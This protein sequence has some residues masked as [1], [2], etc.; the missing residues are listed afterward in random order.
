[1]S[2][3]K[4]YKAHSE[5]PKKY[6]WDLSF[7][8]EGK[9]IEERMKELIS[10]VRGT[11][12]TKDSKYDSKEA[13]LAHFKEDD[14]IS[15]KYFKVH[16]YL[17]NASSLN[18]VDP[19]IT[20]LQQ[21][22]G[23]EMYKISQEVGPEKPRFNKHTKEIKE[24]IKDEAF[25]EY[26]KTI[27]ASIDSQKHDLSPEIQEFRVL[28]S[29]ADIQAD[30]IFSIITNAEL[31]FGVSIDKD[32]NETKITNGN[33]SVL[34]KS[35]DKKV[36]QTASDGYIGGYMT[37][38]AS[39]SNILY[40]HFKSATTWSKLEKFD[41]T[42]DSLVYGDRVD[43]EFLTTLYKSTQKAMPSFKKATKWHGKFYEAKFG[44]KMTK[45]DRAVDLVD[46]KSEYTPE[47]AMDVVIKSVEPFGKE[48]S[49]KVKDALLKENW[50]DFMPVKNKRSGAYSIGA[51]YG[52]DKKLIEMNF[53]GTLRSVETLAHEMGHSMHSY[54]SDSRNGL[55]SSQYP[56][57]VAEIA[58]I[59]N[60]LMLA[61]QLLKESKDDKLKFYILQ[62]LVEGF[63]GTVLRQITWSNYEFDLYDAIEAGKP[64]SSHEALSKFYFESTKKYSTK[65]EAPKYEP[66]RAFEC[67]MVPHYYYG[68]YVYKYAIGQL[69][70]N[71]FFQKYKEEGVEAL[72]E[73][74]D[75]FLSA[76]GTKW[77][78]EILK[79]AG[80]D[81][82][83]PK[84][85]EM[86]FTAFDNVLE[87]W[88]EVGKRIFDVK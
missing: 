14:K 25:A 41:T 18:T 35:L 60:E 20:G 63:Q 69:V 5:V 19:V 80:V 36:R 64:L 30:E 24:W 23:F 68:F 82:K 74:I 78:L 6:K 33:R 86:G 75:K 43:R 87:E 85:Y 21:E 55:V 72:Q 65:E 88:I 29:R 51:S 28:Q 52:I 83:D 71:I 53:D 48:Y 27:Q 3:Q 9:T 32:G 59:F 17:S 70:A 13:Y 38:K 11:I 62:S 37:H 2:K 4:E 66:E 73:F 67:F 8:L 15:K 47:E 84:V 7:L 50:V 56:I 34:M 39:L 46:V 12:A 40:Q 45:Y 26:R 81:L 76:G 77:P 44:E 49:D 31:D 79:D 1:M 42:I 22:L 10:M 54:F 16:N 57:F 58:S 61:D